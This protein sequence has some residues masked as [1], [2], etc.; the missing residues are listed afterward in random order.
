MSV[1]YKGMESIDLYFLES[2][3]SEII[4]GFQP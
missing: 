2:N 4:L 3:T 1:V